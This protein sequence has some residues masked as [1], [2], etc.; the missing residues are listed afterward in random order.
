MTKIDY[1]QTCSVE[2]SNKVICKISAQYVKACRRK[3]RKTVCFQYFKFQKGHYSYK[4]W[5]KLTTLKVDFKYSKTKPWAK[6]QRNMSKHVGEKCGKLYISRIL[7]SKRGITPTKIDGNW[8]HSNLIKCS[9]N[10]SDMQ[11]F[12]SIHCMSKHVGEKCGKLWLTDG[13]PD[14]DPDGRTDGRTDRHHHTIIRPVWRRAYKNWSA[15]VGGWS[16]VW[17]EC[18]LTYLSTVKT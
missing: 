15:L 3:V 2:Q 14:G 10:E 9:L 13:D 7:S 5:R 16:T 18:S 12:S 8:R 17:C 4:N 11:S 6:F 1:T